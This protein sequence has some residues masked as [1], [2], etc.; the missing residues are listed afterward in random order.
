MGGRLDDWLKVVAGRQKQGRG[1]LGRT[2]VSPPGGVYLS[3]LLRPAV[4]APDALTATG[5]AALADTVDELHKLLL[6]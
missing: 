6:G 4:A 1:R 5:A 3:L 2:F